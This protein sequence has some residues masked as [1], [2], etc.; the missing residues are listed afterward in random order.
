MAVAQPESDS[1]SPYAD[2]LPGFTAAWVRARHT[3]VGAILKH[4][5]AKVIEADN[6]LKR[7]ATITVYDKRDIELMSRV[8]FELSRRGFHVQLID[9]TSQSQLIVNWA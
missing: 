6:D 2:I 3:G 9:T 8:L 4:V 1:R 5:E 7:E